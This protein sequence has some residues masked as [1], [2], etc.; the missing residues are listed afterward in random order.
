MQTMLSEGFSFSQFDQHRN[1]GKE[2]ITS[3]NNLVSDS[4]ATI[5][6]VNVTLYA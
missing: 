4:T 3:L 5:E 1:A 2:D 6:N